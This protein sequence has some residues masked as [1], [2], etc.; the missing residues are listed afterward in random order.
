MS[1]LKNNNKS[2]GSFIIFC[3]CMVSI[4]L[5]I[6]NV[7]LA[8]SQGASIKV[9]GI[10]GPIPL[11]PEHP[12]WEL[13]RPYV[14]PLNEQSMSTLVV[15]IATNGMDVGVWVNWGDRSK[16]DSDIGGQVFS[17]QGEILGRQVFSDQVEIQWPILGSG[18]QPFLSQSESNVNIWRW[19]AQ[20]QLN[21][22]ASDTNMWD[23]YN[24]SPSIAWD[25]YYEEPSGGVRN[26]D[27]IGRSLGPFNPEIWSR[28]DTNR[29]R[30]CVTELTS[31]GTL[32]T[33][34]VQ[35]VEGFGSW[36]RNSLLKDRCC[37]EFI[38]SV[39][40][41]RSIHTN[42]PNDVHFSSGTEIPI[43][44]LVWDGR[45]FGKNGVKGTSE[46]FMVQIPSAGQAP[47]IHVPFPD[48]DAGDP[49]PTGCGCG[50]TTGCP[51]TPVPEVPEEDPGSCP[52]GATVGCPCPNDVQYYRGH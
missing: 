26:P 41:K 24:Q 39:V 5:A 36:N 20:C 1:V 34:A 43:A 4:S 10:S 12:Y 38:W 42:D 7:P 11:D 2:F 17:E 19:N 6:W 27:R 35:N 37:S 3:G 45:N 8:I 44:F 31:N 48:E 49:S 33:K 51:C 13:V 25:F 28:I 22:E 40:F 32:T 46:W 15:K 14:I 9:G 23:V 21:R 52:C 30:G 29:R 18:R 16:D 47:G 50:A